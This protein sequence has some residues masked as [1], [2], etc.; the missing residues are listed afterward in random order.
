MTLKNLYDKAGQTV[1]IAIVEPW[2]PLA[3]AKPVASL[4]NRQLKRAMPREVK[5]IEILAKQQMTV[6]LER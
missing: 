3:A 5:T 2:E 1:A 4:S 6:V